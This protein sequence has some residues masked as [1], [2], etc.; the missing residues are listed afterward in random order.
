MRPWCRD[1]QELRGLFG[2]GRALFLGF[3]VL[4]ILGQT[5]AG[6]C[7]WKLRREECL[8]DF[9]VFKAVWARAVCVRKCGKRH[10]SGL[11]LRGFKRASIQCPKISVRENY[12]KRLAPEFC[13]SQEAVAEWACTEGAVRELASGN[14]ASGRLLELLFRNLGSRLR[15]ARPG[16]WREGRFP[17][18]ADKGIRSGILAFLNHL[19]R[20]FR[21]ELPR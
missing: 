19:A 18:S 3:E 16:F 21:P 11:W 17:I 7:V 10:A 4:K 5:Q 1:S 2:S 14:F 12:C 20:G 8:G 15:A 6:F 13:G 9:F